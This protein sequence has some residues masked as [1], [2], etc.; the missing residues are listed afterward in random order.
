MHARTGTPPDVLAK[1]L[2][3]LEKVLADPETQ[4]TAAKRGLK[5]Y[6]TTPAGLDRVIAGD[7]VRV[8]KLIRDHDIKVQ[9][10][11]GCCCPNGSG[12]AAPSCRHSRLGCVRSRL[13][14]PGGGRAHASGPPAAARWR[15]RPGVA[16]WGGRW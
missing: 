9:Q 14:L 15:L 12:A 4:S 13:R 2:A 11:A 8:G 7:T 6:A 3:A 1:L 16:C 10:P 5:A